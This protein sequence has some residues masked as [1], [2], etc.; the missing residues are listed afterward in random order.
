MGF[1]LVL[2]LRPDAHFKWSSE[3]IF[4][5]DFLNGGYGETRTNPY[6][7]HY[8][9]DFSCPVG[10]VVQLL[11]RSRILVKDNNSSGDEGKMLVVQGT[12]TGWTYRFMHLSSFGGVDAGKLYDAGH[13]VAKSGSTGNSKGPHSHVEASVL[14]GGPTGWANRDPRI[15]LR[16]FLREAYAAKRW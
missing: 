11:E 3:L 5:D 6:G 1:Q 16:P 7:Y 2:P 12:F 9:Q 14:S 10:T 4:D 15:N 8:A 13:A